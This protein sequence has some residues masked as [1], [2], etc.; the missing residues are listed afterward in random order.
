MAKSSI[1]WRRSRIK[2]I[3]PVRGEID[4]TVE[5]FVSSSADAASVL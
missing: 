4:K 3:S 2:S 5:M 1:G